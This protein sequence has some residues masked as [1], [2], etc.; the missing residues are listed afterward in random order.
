[1]SR[2]RAENRLSEFERTAL[3]LAIRSIVVLEGSYVSVVRGARVRQP[4]VSLALH[5]RLV[6]KTPAVER[7]FEYLG[8][9]GR[10]DAAVTT[11]AGELPG[12]R[13]IR[14]SKLVGM[15]EG[16]S[17]GSKAADNRLAAILAALRAFLSLGVH[18]PPS[19]PR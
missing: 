15:L 19:A 1:M 7:L 17:D 4:L 2:P 14:A 11:D 12:G 5:Q 8:I 6:V 9:E 3:S 10:A 13:D 16:L 18:Q